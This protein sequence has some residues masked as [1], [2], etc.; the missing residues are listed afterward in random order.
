MTLGVSVTGDPFA[1]CQSDV[2]NHCILREHLVH[3]DSVAAACPG[4]VQVFSAR[5]PSLPYS[6]QGRPS[7]GGQEAGIHQCE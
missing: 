5:A 6:P 4:Q 7:S 1:L 2:I 3:G